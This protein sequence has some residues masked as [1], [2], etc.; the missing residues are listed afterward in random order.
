MCAINGFNWRDPGLLLAMNKAT[1]H[2]GPDASGVFLDDGVSL[3][4]NRLSIIDL[5]SSANQPMTGD[6]GRLT[7]VFNGEI[8]NFRELKKELE[9]DYHFR[10][11]SDTEVILAAYKK[12]GSLCVE[13]FNGIFAFAVWDREKQ[14][15]FLA[16]DHVG[17]KPLY[18][19][20]NPQNGKFIF[21]SEIKAILEHPIPRE[22]DSAALNHYLKV[23]YVPA[24]LTMFKHVYKFP[25]AS[26]GIFKNNKLK[27]APFWDAKPQALPAVS[28]AELARLV[29][30]R[31]Y[32]S[33]KKQLVSDRP[34]GVYL[35][36]GM[37][38]SAV[39]HS[40][41]H[42][43]PSASRGI[44][45]FTVGFELTDAEERQKFNADA[46]YA[47]K[48]AQYYG[49][50]H[51]EVWVASGQ[52]IDN[53]EKA[54][55]HMDEPI[56]HPTAVPMLLLA[57]LAK[58]HIA[59]V[60]GGDGGDELFG[61]DE[62]FRLSRIADAYQ[63]L[64][65]RLRIF[66]DRHPRL[67]KLNIPVGIERYSLLW[68]NKSNLREIIA[69]EFL[70]DTVTRNFFGS[71]IAE[72][73][74]ESFEK[75][76]MLIERKSW[77]VDYSLALTDKMTMASGLE[78][79]VPL[80]D[81]DMIEMSLSIPVK[82][83]LSLA[84]KLNKKIILREAFKNQLPEFLFKKP[85]SGWF[86]P[87]AKWLRHPEFSQFARNILSAGYCAETNK[88]FN[89]PVVQKILDGHI[90]GGAYNLISIWALLTFQVWARRFNVKL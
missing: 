18:Y 90:R 23:L 11:R 60:F 32:E 37:D 71:L 28:K 85:K 12:W 15:L 36:G 69:P 41:A 78:E 24:P 43:S 42:N 19:Y 79:R 14:E 54:V 73:S 48:T 81:K 74:E 55:W 64:P 47:R 77:L 40:I 8:Y 84:S 59:V 7:V 87:G 88:I 75:T 86:S 45:T 27:T 68:F 31:V 58:Q 38:S 29:R 16:R 26:F 66:L 20:H 6:D 80:L 82:Y 83:K 56:S 1:A 22:F 13:K 39:L 50:N 25:P 51:H 53:F 30:E 76:L 89:W 44:N 5:N 4:H 52:V 9:G 17:V 65:F 49:T 72:S 46:E 35:S 61:G 10:T 62:R 3:G 57:Q 33:V 63:K 34:V 2:R 67:K 70:D 21:A